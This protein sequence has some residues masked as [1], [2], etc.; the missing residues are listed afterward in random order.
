M[1]AVVES[2]DALRGA[3]A[4]ELADALLRYARACVRPPIGRFEHPWLAPM[5]ASPVVHAYLHGSSSDVP[6]RSDGFVEGDYGLG[7]FS[8]DVGEAAIELCRYSDLREAC[9][10]SLLCLLDCADPSGKVHRAELPHKTRDFEP[11]KPGLV[12]LALHVVEG[13]GPDGEETAARHRFVPRLRAHI[14]HYEDTLTGGHGL[15]LT[16]SARASGFDNDPLSAGCPS[17]TVE[18]PDTNALM[19]LDYE[20]LATLAHRLGDA[21]IEAWA[22]QRADTL[23]RRIDR[24]MWVEDDRGGFY[25]ALRWAHGVADPDAERVRAPDAAGIVRPLESWATLLPLAAAVAPPLRAEA[26]IRR[27]LDPAGYWGPSGVRTVPRWSPLHHQAP[28]AMMWDDRKGHAGLVSNWCGPVWILSNHH[29]AR[30]LASQGHD[31]AARELALTSARLLAD[32]LAATGSL[33]E[34]YAD[35]GRGL[36]PPRGAFVSWN[37]LALTMLR[38]HAAPPERR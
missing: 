2:A 30:A 27:L 19:V 29:I 10:G 11:A 5:P 38:D 13:E 6:A 36:W 33:H 3:E 23:R 9:L 32:D 24:M 12:R 7:L 22:L 14:R 37:V 34:C 17:A 1:S 15:L 25:A 16:P 18:G 20:A 35:D 31:Q 8:H 21:S 26:M 4:S 28:R